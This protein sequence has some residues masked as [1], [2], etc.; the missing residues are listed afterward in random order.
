MPQMNMG[1]QW[2]SP[3]WQFFVPSWTMFQGPNPPT[4]FVVYN[5][6]KQMQ[7]LWMSLP[8]THMQSLPPI[9]ILPTFNQN[10]HLPTGLNQT[11]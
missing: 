5:Q 8:P 3:S 10:Q 7:N 1:Y 2:L 9:Q 6:Y 4:R 11:L